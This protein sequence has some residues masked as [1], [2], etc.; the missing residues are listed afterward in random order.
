MEK[1]KNM[2][3]NLHSNEKL[4][5]IMPS[6]FAIITGLL[7]GFIIMLIT[8][9]S[10]AGSGL[11]RILF[12][13]FDE[14]PKS[15]GQVLYFATPIILT[16]LSVGFAFKT[17]LFNI[18]ATGQFT[19]GA[20]AAIYVG[21]NWGFL[22]GKFHWLIAILVATIIGG[23]WGIIPG[24]LK[25]YRNVHEVVATIMMNYIAVYLVKWFI[26]S[27]QSIYNQE[28][29]ET[30]S[31]L[32][33]AK[34]PSLFMKEIFKGS[35]VDGGFIVAVVVAIIIYI[36]L[37]KTTFGFE[38]KAVGHNRHSAKYAGINEKRSIILSMAIAGATAG[39][40]GAVTFL[41][42]SL[43]HMEPLAVLLPQ[44]FDGITV[45]LI[46]LSNPIGVIF[47]G[48]FIGYI[49]QGGFTMQLSGFVPEII[50]I[51]TSAIIYFSALSLIFQSFIK[52][53]LGKNGGNK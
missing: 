22:P 19:V 21:V 23:I 47:A 24:L 30:A 6:I 34:N 39:L 43:K 48:I 46:A 7:F 16:G 38:L 32:S 5:S 17:G 45:A 2:F 25:A 8:N 44:G 50:G 13:A 49:K 36:V 26:L 18:G 28:K 3:R 41:S 40:A 53:I 11:A 12:G 20:I 37:N 4:L 35:Q 1:I 27:N 31:V 14:G 42:V 10:G 33:T 52:K 9:P 51:I 29:N 15:L